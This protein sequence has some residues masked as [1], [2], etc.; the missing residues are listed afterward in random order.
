[1]A[2]LSSGLESVCVEGSGAAFSPAALK[3]EYAGTGDC[4]CVLRI[5][6]PVGAEADGDSFLIGCAPCEYGAVWEG[7]G[8]GIIAGPPAPRG[9][10][11]AGPGPPIIICERTPPPPDG[12]GPP[13]PK[14]PISTSSIGTAP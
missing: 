13:G 14:A 2:G 11:P 5:S 3:G 12:R 8:A 9:G 10:G 7:A 6:W 4:D 1:M